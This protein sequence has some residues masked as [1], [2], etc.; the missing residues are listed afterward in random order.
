MPTFPEP[1]RYSTPAKEDKIFNWIEKYYKWVIIGLLIFGSLA[2]YFA[3]CKS[4]AV[5][6][7][8]IIPTKQVV[9]QVNKSE[10]MLTKRVDSLQAIIKTRDSKILS[11]EQARKVNKDKFNEVVN[12]SQIPPV[13]GTCTDE[14][15]EHQTGSEYTEEIKQ[16]A[17]N[18]IA[19]D[20]EIID[21][22]HLQVGSYISQLAIQ[23]EKYSVLKKGFE[24]VVQNDSINAAAA[25]SLNKK[26]KWQK[27]KTGFVIGAAIGVIGK[28]LIK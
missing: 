15:I 2:F 21:S 9:K 22:L 20:D 5:T 3:A 27:L 14:D 23:D 25:K 24:Q 6:Q 16:A 11:L 12:R 17:V 4:D 18:V 26:L 28:I 10:E 13:Q 7:A 8:I 1:K 19:G